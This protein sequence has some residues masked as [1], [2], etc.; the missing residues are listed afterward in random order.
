MD[1]LRPLTIEV[2]FRSQGETVFVATTWAGFLGVFTGMRPGQWSASLNFRLTTEG[3]FWGNLKSTMKGATPSGFLLRHL[4]ESE[5]T[6]D[7]AVQALASTPLIAPCYFTVCGTLQGEGALITRGPKEEF[8]RWL[9]SEAGTIV[10]TNIDHWTLD[11]GRDIMDSVARRELAF[12]ALESRPSELTDDWL[13]GM[14]STPPILNDITIYATLMVPNERR[15]ITALPHNRYGYKPKKYPPQEDAILVPAKATYEE[16]LALV[17]VPVIPKSSCSLCMIDYGPYKN[18]SGECAHSGTWHSSFA[19]CNYVTCGAHLFPTN[20][21][22]CHWSC[23]Y[24]ISQD[25]LVCT[26]SGKHVPNG[27]LAPAEEDVQ[28][29]PEPQAVM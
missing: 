17:S 4:L 25:D 3:T 15:L 20:I 27:P 19:D 12:S 16:Y 8:N 24:S 6:Y 21:G 13:W 22:K 26:K 5:P 9:L 2:D 23:C 14:M 29:A 28:D 18:K 7:G 11:D 10:Q 1:V